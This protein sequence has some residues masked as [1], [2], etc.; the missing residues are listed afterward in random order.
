MRRWLRRFRRQPPELDVL[1]AYARWAATYSPDSH[2]SLM[3]IEQQAMLDLLPDL[4]GLC[5]LDLACGSGRYAR[6][7]AERGAARVF[8]FDLSPHMLARARSV[9]P[10]L[11]RSDLRT[12][13]LASASVDVIVC[14]LAVGHIE[15]LCAAI[16]E[17]AR[18]LAPNG[19]LVYS[20]FHPFGQIAG[21]RRAFRGDDGREYAVR[22]HV[23]WYADH[24]AACRVAGLH[25]EDVREPRIDFQRAWRGAPAVLVIRTRK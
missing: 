13:P 8:G 1:D 12:I 5:V 18:V 7:M 22:H 23:H 20:D 11:A 24:H 17:M 16:A 10:N 21:W 25:I 2:N 9:T 14:G 19:C 3:H 4:P 6:L 15:D